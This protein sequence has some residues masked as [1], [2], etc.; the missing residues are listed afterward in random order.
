[1]VW[2]PHRVEFC[3]LGVGGDLGGYELVGGNATSPIVL[4]F[5]IPPS[6]GCGRRAQSAS[7]RPTVEELLH[8]H[9]VEADDELVADL[10]DRR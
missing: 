7:G 5:A 4:A 3:P 10:Q 6:H 9:Q 1:M 2:K 8:G